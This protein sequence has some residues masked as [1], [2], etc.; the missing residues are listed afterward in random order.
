MKR[1]ASGIRRGYN[2]EATARLVS[3]PFNSTD[4]IEESEIL[5]GPDRFPGDTATDVR[6]LDMFRPDFETVIPSE[7]RHTREE[8][9][10]I[11]KSYYDDASISFSVTSR[12][13]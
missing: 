4:E 7:K 13:E 11:A 9:Y 2:G 12:D 5:L 6:I 1:V 3:V 8:L 10:K